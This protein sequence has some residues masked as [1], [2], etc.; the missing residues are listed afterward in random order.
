MSQI[1]KYNRTL[2]LSNAKTKSCFKCGRDDH[3]A[4]HEKCRAKGAECTKCKK[5]GHYAKY[6]RSSGAEKEERKVNLYSRHARI[7]MSTT[8]NTFT[9]L[10]RKGDST[11]RL[12][13]K[14]MGNQ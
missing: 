1:N 7:Q 12:M 2:T 6:G 4:N 9:K 11:L 14:L 5:I 8:T 3:L 10:F 13:L